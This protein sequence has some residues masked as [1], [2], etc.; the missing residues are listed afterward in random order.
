MRRDLFKGVVLGAVV[1]TVVQMSVAALAGTGMGAVFNLGQTNKVNAPSALKGA[2]SGRNLV[3]T[4]TGT[5]AGLGITVRAGKRPI[6]VNSSAGKAT[7]LNADKLDG[8]DSTAFV[9]TSACEPPPPSSS[10]SWPPSSRR[11]P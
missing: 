1:A 6:I 8:L 2:T 4:N 10:P 11:S 7:N 5:G 3:I 9:K